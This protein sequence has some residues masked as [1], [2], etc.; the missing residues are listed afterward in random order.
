[1]ERQEIEVF[2]TL[3]EELHF[4]RTAVKLRLSP[5]RVTQV[6]QKIERQIGAPLFDRT[7]RGAHLT[8]LGRRFRDNL[9]PA[10]EAVEAAI[11]GAVAEGRGIG[12]ELR[13]GFF[14]PFTGRQMT[15]LADAFA[16]QHPGATAQVVLEVE[17][18]K[19]LRPLLEG[20]VD[21]LA[22]L[23]PVDQPGLVVGPTVVRDPI[24]MG[25]PADHPLAEK[26]TSSMEDLGDYPVVNAPRGEAWSDLFAP[27]KT[28]SGRPINLAYP[29]ETVQAGMSLG[30]A[31]KGI[32][33]LISQLAKY[34]QY[35]EV[36][37]RPLENAPVCEIGLV[38]QAAKET[39]LV[40]AFARFAAERG[41]VDVPWRPEDLR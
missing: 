13:L 36:T 14:G 41:P 21:V 10:H 33:A 40:R 7:T 6:V 28:P 20:R 19:P 31:G 35:P 26:A 32:G 11:R 29:I 3:C 22:T 2:L 8:E 5:A 39:E 16:A 34:H 12:G 4:G 15:A 24:V 23:L 18:G 37:Y 38:W 30:S 1:M 9:A 17:V 27:E 25:M